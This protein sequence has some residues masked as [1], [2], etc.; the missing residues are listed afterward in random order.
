MDEHRSEACPD[1]GRGDPN[2]SSELTC[3]ELVEFLDDYLE[4]ELSGEH[5]AVFERHLAACAD[6]RNYLDSYRETIRLS[7]EALEAR[8]VVEE[9]P[10]ELL[11]AILESKK[12]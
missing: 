1:G 2:G 4:G 10:E 11:R 6:C 8:P 3:R 9:I 7:G 5:D 12:C